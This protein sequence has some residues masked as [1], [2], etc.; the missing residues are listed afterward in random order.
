MSTARHTGS[1]AH[2]VSATFEEQRAAFDENPMPAWHTRRDRLARL[3]AL[4]CRN[5]AALCDAIDR[6]FGGRP[7][8]ETRLAEIFPVRQSIR[9]AMRHGHRWMRPTPRSVSK[10]FRPATA[11]L[12]PQPLGV[13][14]IVASWNFPLLLTL[15]PLVCALAAGNRAMIKVSDFSPAFGEELSAAISSCF[16]VDEVAVV[17]GDLGV[18]RAFVSMPFD[19]LLFTGSSSTGRAVM[20]AA[21]ENL[22]PVTLELG[23][24]C[25][26]VVAPGAASRKTVRRILA[27][28]L[29][30][31]GQACIAPDYVLVHADELQ[32]WIG[33]CRQEASA[34]LPQGWADPAFCAI[35]RVDDRARLRALNDEAVQA[36]T[37]AIPLVDAGSDSVAAA[38]RVAPTLL[39]NPPQHL[40]VATEEV[41]GPLLPVFTYRHLSEAMS[42]VRA[43]PR[44]LALYWF[45]TDTKRAKEAVSLLH[46]GGA[47]INET[48]VHIAQ[49]ELPFGGIGQSGMGAYHGKAGFLTFSHSKPVFYQGRFNAMGLLTPPVGTFGRKVLNWMMRF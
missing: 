35:A 44:P 10:W 8:L 6:D 2:D 46:A 49:D 5:E 23:G 40:R 45:D 9:H 42:F 33:A 47:C 43:R 30:N 16:S 29:L 26:A 1:E 34:M 37:L 15:S 48:L 38:Y 17:C 19:H 12:V 36:G 27:G 3:D 39:I 21:S 31:A 13:V 11:A 7:A 41:F 22:T 25:P 32:S 20:R 4:L 18:A 28:K 14:G 24:K